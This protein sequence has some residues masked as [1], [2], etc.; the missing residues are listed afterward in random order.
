MSSAPTAAAPAA[1]IFDTT[2]PSI[3][4]IHNLIR[5]K[6]EIEVKLISGDSFKGTLKWIDTQCLCIDGLGED[7]GH[8]M[9][10]WLNAIAFVKYRST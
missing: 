3:K 7:R 9:V 10:I 6:Q 8:S 5:D 1:P 2:I 4:R